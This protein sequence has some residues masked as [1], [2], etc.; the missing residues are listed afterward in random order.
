MAVPLGAP[1]AIVSVKLGTATKSASWAVPGAT[2]SVSTVAAA[3]AAPST[4]AVTVIALSPSAS[5]TALGFTLSVAPMG[6][7]SSSSIVSVWAAGADTPPPDAVADT[8]TDLSGAWTRLSTAVIVTAPVLL[9]DPAAIV[10]VVPDWVKSAAAAPS[11]GVEDTVSVTAACAGPL[12]VAVTVLT[13]LFPLSS[14]EVGV[15]TSVAVGAASSSVIVISSPVTVSEPERPLT[16]MVSLGSSNASSVG[17]RVKVPVPLAWP[18]AI[19]MLKPVTV[20]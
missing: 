8:V 9:V 5:P 20:P 3:R 6:A 10:S 15:S 1:A 14:I 7:A 19:V 4:V 11:P 16:S 18:A 2:E 13:W 17:V 12:S